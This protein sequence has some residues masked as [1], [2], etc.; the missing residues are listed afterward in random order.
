MRIA[1]TGT[2]GSGKTTLVEDFTGAHQHYVQEAEPYWALV[3]QGTPFADAPTVADLETQLEAS[4]SMFLASDQPDVVFDRCPLD[5]IAYLD[6]V[7]AAE[8]F[9]WSPHAK[10]LPRI[11]RAIRSLDL[12]VF[13]PL[14]RPDEIEVTIEYP[15]LRARVD[16]LLKSIL[17][18]DE[19]GLFGDKP[20]LIEIRGTRAER[21][22]RLSAAAGL[23][24]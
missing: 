17:R 6:V 8:G 10:L 18:D 14:S 15:K 3:Q 20:R 13:L 16:Q 24:R 1:V 2:H 11:E 5:F 19:L 7:S 22:E 12:L 21:L 9:E 23:D 4:C